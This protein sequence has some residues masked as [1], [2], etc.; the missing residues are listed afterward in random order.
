MKV[1]T[2]NN[3]GRYNL[4]KN[5]AEGD[6]KMNPN[7]A[8]Y[9]S[10]GKKRKVVDT[11][12]VNFLQN[13]LSNRMLP[14]ITTI[15]KLR[16]PDGV[17]PCVGNL[18]ARAT[19]TLKGVITDAARSSAQQC[20]HFR[21]PGDA[22]RTGRYVTIPCS[23][24]TSIGSPGLNSPVM[25]SGGTTVSHTRPGIPEIFNPKGFHRCCGIQG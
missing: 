8:T 23:C 25:I 15:I 20:P 18:H 14:V 22:S 16:I 12:D 10:D 3:A 9:T 21:T 7:V 2:I 24:N 5:D 17:V 6:P 4:D 1:S 11:T 13:L 19:T